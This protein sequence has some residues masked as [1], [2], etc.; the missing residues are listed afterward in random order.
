V[1]IKTFILLTLFILLF[2]GY[3][4]DKKTTDH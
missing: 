4:S 3:C 1:E 2:L